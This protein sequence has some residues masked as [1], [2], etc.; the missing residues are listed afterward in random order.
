MEIQQ[1]TTNM[2]DYYSEFPA[3]SLEQAKNEIIYIARIE[4]REWVSSSDS[5][6]NMNSLVSEAF[7]NSDVLDDDNKIK[8]SLMGWNVFGT[9]DV[10]DAINS[11]LEKRRKTKLR[12]KIR[13]LLRATYLLIKANKSSIEKI[14][15]PDSHYVNNVLKNDFESQISNKTND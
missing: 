13:G 6:D 2:M 14:Y 7:R 12:R 5:C 1:L 15:H 9:K 11:I 10:F 3:P 4:N 8:Y